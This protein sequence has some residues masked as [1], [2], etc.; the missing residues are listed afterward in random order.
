MYTLPALMFFIIG[1]IPFS[2]YY[3]SKR[4]KKDE[5]KNIAEIRTF[6]AMTNLILA[7]SMFSTAALFSLLSIVFPKESNTT[8]IWGIIFFSLLFTTI[9]STYRY[10]KF[11][12]KIIKMKKEFK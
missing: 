11:K 5:N 1:V 12:S 8:I 9:F 4:K 3:A 6:M 10:M 7:L 2:I